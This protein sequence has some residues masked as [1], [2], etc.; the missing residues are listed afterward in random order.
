MKIRQEEV[1]LFRVD[2][3]TDGQKHEHDEANSR[4]SQLFKRA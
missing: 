3:R 4:T 2:G 1:Q